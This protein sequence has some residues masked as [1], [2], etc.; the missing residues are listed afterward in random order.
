PTGTIVVTAPTGATLEY[1]V[2]GVTY[3]STLIFSGLIPGNYNVTVRDTATGCVS[4]A[5]AVTVNPIPANPSAPT[6]VAVS[7]STCAVVTG[8]ITVTS[9]LGSNFEYSIDGITYQSLAAFL[10]LSANTYF[11]T[12]RDTV[13]GCVSSATSEVVR[14]APVAPVAPTASVTVQPTCTTPTGTIVVTAPTGATLEY[15]VNGM[16]Y[17]STMIFTGLASGNYNVT[18]RDTVTGCVSSATVVT[19]NPLPANPA[20]PT[21]SV[22][23]QPTC[24]ITTGTI[25]VTVP[26]GASFEYSIDG[27][28]YQSSTTFSGLASGNYTVTVRDINTGCISSGTALIVN[29]V[30]T[31]IDVMVTEGCVNGSYTL[32]SSITDTVNYTYEWLNASGMTIGTNQPTLVVTLPGNYTLEVTDVNGGCVSSYGLNVLSAYCEIP[33]GI[34]PNG[35]TKND[36]FDLTGLNPKKV[37]IFNRYGMKVFNY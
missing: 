20:A 16:N 32:T 24:I 9:P 35:D 6:L 2:D 10:N 14:P 4:S 30:S 23:V 15:S 25:E 37:E 36:A 26:T 22:T 5:T 13:T 7:P 33:K 28:N 34:S 3:Q 12:V 18:V 21:A 8:S 27:I 29:T 19:V 31:P 1:S 11:V 17:Q